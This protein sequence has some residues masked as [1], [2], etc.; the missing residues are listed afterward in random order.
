MRN[1]KTPAART[2]LLRGNP[3]TST[4]DQGF[5]RL[6]SPRMINRTL[7]QLQK[8][9]T[10]PRSAKGTLPKE[11]T[12]IE[13]REPERDRR[14][15]RRISRSSTSKKVS[16]PCREGSVPGQKNL[17]QGQKTLPRHVLLLVGDGSD[18]TRSTANPPRTAEG[19]GS[20]LRRVR[21]C[22]GKGNAKNASRGKKPRIHGSRDLKKHERSTAPPAEPKETT[23]EMRDIRCL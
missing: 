7:Q 11:R 13:K 16:P 6:D 2:S 4:V 20:Y 23:L 9:K 18:L 5:L 15:H 12:V 1:L 14:S 17:N 19:G 21:R 22:P 3:T 8:R 10:P